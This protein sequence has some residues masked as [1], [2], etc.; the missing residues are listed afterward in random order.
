MGDTGPMDHAVRF[1]GLTKYFGALHAVEDL[2]FNAI[3]AYL[4]SSLAALVS[5]LKP[6]RPLSPFWWYSGHDPLNHG[7]EALHML[8]LVAVTLVCTTAAVFAFERRDLA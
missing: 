2:S 8:L 4:L 5:G 6:L 1:D 3:A 7:L